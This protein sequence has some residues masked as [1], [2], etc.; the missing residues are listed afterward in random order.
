MH[1]HSLVDQ[2]NI[3]PSGQNGNGQGGNGQTGMEMVVD[4][5]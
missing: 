2:K 4:K 3:K 5:W 1:I